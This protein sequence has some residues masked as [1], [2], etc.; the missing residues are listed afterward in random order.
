MNDASHTL[1][2]YIRE[3]RSEL[4]CDRCG[5]YIGSLSASRYVPPP[6]P[7]AIEHID[8]DDEAATLIGFEWHMLGLLRQNKF[9]I[10][11]P[12]SKGRCVSIREWYA[13]Q[14]EDEQDE[15]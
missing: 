5:R 13:E 1:G 14:D 4:V 3:I 6:Y 9:T 11:H 15:D 2:D 12:Q 7:V 10:R 8:G